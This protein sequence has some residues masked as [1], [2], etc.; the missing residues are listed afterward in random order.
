MNMGKENKEE[1]LLSWAFREAKKADFL[2]EEERERY[3]AALIAAARWGEN[4]K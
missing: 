1:E 2:T 3:A 4:A